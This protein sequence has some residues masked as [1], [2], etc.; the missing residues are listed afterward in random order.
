MIVYIIVFADGFI[1]DV[2]PTLRSAQLLAQAFDGA[3]EMWAEKSLTEWIAIG[4][5]TRIILRAYKS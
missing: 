2:C 4:S 1:G 5:K 3:I